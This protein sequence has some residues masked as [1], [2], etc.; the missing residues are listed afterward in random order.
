MVNRDLRH[1]ECKA[2]IREIN[3]NA[4]KERTNAEYCCM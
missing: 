1:E 3:L 4:R 2:Y